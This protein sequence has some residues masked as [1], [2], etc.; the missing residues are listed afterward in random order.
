[1][2][3]RIQFHGE[4]EPE[5]AALPRDVRRGLLAH[6]RLLETY[7]PHL[8]R[9][10]ADTLK[11]SRFDNMK[12]LRFSVGNGVWHVAFAFDPRRAGILLVAGDKVGGNQRRFYRN[13][14]ATADRRYASHLT[15]QER[16]GRDDG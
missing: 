11:G 16:K 8:K 12:E 1:M 5:F 3:W 7:G 6:A 2:S 4:F 13:L 14:I 15:A 10:H 9:P